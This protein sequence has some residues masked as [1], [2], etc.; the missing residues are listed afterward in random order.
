MRLNG[1]GATPFSS[2]PQFPQT[3]GVLFAGHEEDVWR[4]MNLGHR[5]SKLAQQ[6]NQALAQS[7]QSGREETLT[8]SGN[9][10]KLPIDTLEDIYELVDNFPHLSSIQIRN[11]VISL[12]K[13]RALQAAN[14]EGRLT[15]DYYPE[16]EP[17]KED[18][19][20]Y[21]GLPKEKR[22]SDL[23]DEGNF[24]P[25]RKSQ[26][27]PFAQT[28]LPSTELTDEQ[29]FDHIV[30]TKAVPDGRKKHLHINSD[31]VFQDAWQKFQE[32]FPSA[33]L[34]QERARAVFNSAFN[35]NKVRV[36]LSKE[37]P[38]IW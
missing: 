11:D 15:I 17:T 3:K 7:G 34:T 25:H 23:Y 6:R 8:G 20:Y 38:G 18:I 4:R 1:F 10:K 31:A 2:T 26:P 22:Y 9:Y 21:R 16:E 12:K 5:N 27:N 28:P 13:A 36:T 29:W 19:A 35:K 14:Q 33:N 32:K 37:T 30:R 24:V